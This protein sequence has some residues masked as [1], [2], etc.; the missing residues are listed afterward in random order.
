MHNI[1]R[2]FERGIYIPPK[3]D[4]KKC[5]LWRKLEKLSLNGFTSDNFFCGQD[6]RIYNNQFYDGCPLLF[7]AWQDEDTP[8]LV[9]NSLIKE[10][11][12]PEELNDWQCIWNNFYYN[13]KQHPTATPYTRGWYMLIISRLRKHMWVF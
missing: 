13:R 1:E 12:S 4:R 5:G 3:E 9:Y 6:G 10:K 11:T 2:G 8:V 7:V